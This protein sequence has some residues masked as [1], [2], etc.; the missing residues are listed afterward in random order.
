MEIR[1][2][3]VARSDRNLSTASNAAI[4]DLP[5]ETDKGRNRL[6]LIESKI[7]LRH[8]HQLDASPVDSVLSH[9]IKMQ[10]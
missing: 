1:Q 10:A 4:F 9:V 5:D 8:A 6:N 3:C 7:A 2:P